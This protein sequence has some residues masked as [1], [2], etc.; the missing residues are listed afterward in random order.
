[1]NEHDLQ[2]PE[3]IIDLSRLSD[4]QIEQLIVEGNKILK[5]RK[6]SEIKHFQAETRRKAKEKGLKVSFEE[7]STKTRAKSGA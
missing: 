7:L 2:T 1:M 6:D 4:G 5:K 3:P